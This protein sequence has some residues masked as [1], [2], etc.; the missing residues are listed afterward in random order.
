MQSKL[1]QWRASEHPKELAKLLSTPTLS[2]A[3]NLLRE[4]TAPK[5]A[6]PNPGDP[7]LDCT[8]AM[9]WTSGVNFAL[10]SFIAL[11]QQNEKHNRQLVRQPWDHIQPEDSPQD[12]E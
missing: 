5:L 11:A 12:N 4:S 10:D 1:D 2:E 3:I 6:R 7:P 8:A 9:W